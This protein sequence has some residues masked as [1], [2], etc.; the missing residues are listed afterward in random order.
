MERL[1]ALLK[2]LFINGDYGLLFMGRLV[3][4]IGDGVH[5]FAITWLILDLTSSGTALST[6]LLFSSLPSIVLAPFTGV[7]ADMWDRKKIVVITDIIRGLILLAVAA[8][9]AAGHLTLG[10]I[11]GATAL[12]SICSVLFGPAISAAIP[13]MV[14][15][16]ELTAANVRNNFARS[17]TGIIGP[18]L[19]AMLVGL[20]G[21]TAV[22]AIT[23]ICFLLSAISEM[24]IRFP[25]QEFGTE[26]RG[27]AQFKAY[28]ANFKEGFTYIW[29]D[30]SLRALIGFAVVLNFIAAPIFSIVLPYFG[31]EVLNM[32]AEHFGI[33]KSSSPIGLLIGT[34]LVGIFTKRFPK[35]KLLV[36][37]VVGQGLLGV[38]IGLVA[39]PAFYTNVSGLVLLGS[40][41]VPILLIGILNVMV[42]VPFQVMLQET[43]PDSY[44][45][46]VFGLLDGLVSMLVPVG[47]AV[48]GPVVD[49]VAPA[50]VFLACSAAL[51]LIGALMGRSQ[52]VARLYSGIPGEGAPVGSG[53]Q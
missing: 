12:S 40:L 28:G 53:A 34:F 25:E 6:L 48:F 13:G 18:S 35:T 30:V 41:V 11:Y 19:G 52:S 1:R 21:Y 26:M 10:V 46:R 31:K 17:A 15:R 14:K 22:F 8:I 23:G 51:T 39:F 2:K 47:M 16:E 32:P 9:Y 7:L 4:Q 38:V 49:A 42:N 43:V 3:S 29:Q 50:V 44:R 27:A 45:G 20:T 36:G 37:G 33:V 24:F 5:Y